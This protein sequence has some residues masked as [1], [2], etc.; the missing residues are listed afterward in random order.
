MIWGYKW[1]DSKQKLSIE[2]ELDHL[3]TTF[4]FLA[5]LKSV[6]WTFSRLWTDTPATQVWYLWYNYPVVSPSAARL[7]WHQ[8]PATAW[9][10][11]NSWRRT[12]RVQEMYRYDRRSQMHGH[13]SP[14]AVY[15]TVERWPSST[16]VPTVSR[17]F[18]ML[19]TVVWDTNLYAGGVVCHDLFISD[20]YTVFLGTRARY[21]PCTPFS[22]AQ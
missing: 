6:Y 5:R 21:V 3:Y 15:T 14:S 20:I 10:M 1:F 4:S 13:T 11:G 17:S 12:R 7:I 22:A 16:F 2:G 8:N 9:R 18:L 19:L